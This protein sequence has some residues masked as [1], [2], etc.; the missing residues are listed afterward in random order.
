[1]YFKSV[2]LI[3][4]CFLASPRTLPHPT[5]AP[6]SKHYGKELREAQGDSHQGVEALGLTV[7][8]G[9]MNL[10]NTMEGGKEVLLLW[11]LCCPQP[12]LSSF[13]GTLTAAFMKDLEG[14]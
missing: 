5:P 11:W 3:L 4:I 1:M 12:Q 10:V 2:G 14:T 7:Y 9:I 8:S 6:N 13:P